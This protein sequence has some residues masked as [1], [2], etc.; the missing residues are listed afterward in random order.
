MAFAHFVLIHTICHGAWI[1]HKLKPLLEALGHKVT[2]LDLAASGVDPRQIEEIGSFD[3]YSEPL[4]TFLE[5]LPPGEKV[6]LVGESCGGLN[7]AIA[8]DKYCEK[9]AAAVFH[10]SVL[11]DTEHCPSY[12]VD[13]LMEVF[14]DW[15]DT[16]YFTYTKDGKEITGLKLGFTLLRENL[17]T[18]C[19]PEE[20]ELA[21]MLTRKGSLFQNI[22]AK[23][24]FFTKE[25]YGS[26]K[27]I[28]VWTDQDE[29][30]LPEFQLWQIENYKPDKVYK[31]EGGDHLLQLTKTK[32]IA[33]ILQE[34]ADTY[35]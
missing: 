13:K 23:R 21:K 14:P 11:P 7:I 3:E 24:P 9:I 6:I 27:K 34:V 19:G 4:L 5:A 8:A 28:Y 33:E 17:Y 20:Y 22:L 15:K 10:N 30:F 29:I 26:I 32:E 18:L 25:G 31:V 35:N 2:A 1:W 16:T 12:V